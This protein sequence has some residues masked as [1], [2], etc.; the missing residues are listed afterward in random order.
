[1]DLTYLTND[2]LGFLNGNSGNP[3]V[4][5]QQVASWTICLF[6]D[7]LTFCSPL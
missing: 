3:P 4:I 5:V 1:M 2:I 6:V 7:D